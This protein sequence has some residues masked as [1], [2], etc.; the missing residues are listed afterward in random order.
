MPLDPV[1]V[2]IVRAAR[3]H[4][5]GGDYA[6]VEKPLAGSPFLARVYRAAQSSALR[7]EAAPGTATLDEM[8]RLSIADPA[9]PVQVGDIAYLPRLNGS[10]TRARIVRLRFYSD[11]MQYDLET[12]AEGKSAPPPGE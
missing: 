11:R 9:C 10:Y 12:G 2:V 7:D 4:I 8:Q 6:E 5:G 3:T 1:P